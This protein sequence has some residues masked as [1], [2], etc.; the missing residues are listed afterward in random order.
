[1]SSSPRLIVLLAAVIFLGACLPRAFA[2]ELTLSPHFHMPG[3]TFYAALTYQ[4]KSTHPSLFIE[5]SQVKA[6]NIVQPS[7]SP[8]PTYKPTVSQDTTTQNLSDGLITIEE[9]I[10]TA[11][12]TPT[13]TPTPTPTS[14]PTPMPTPQPIVT[15][16]DLESLFGKYAGEYSV[17]KEQLKKIANCES[18]FNAGASFLDY[19]GMFQFS[20]SSWSSTRQQMNQDP[21]PDLRYNAEESI[22]TAAFKIS[23]HGPSAWPSC[24]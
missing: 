7:S 21:N 19:G 5:F 10:P 6:F 18:G 11:T 23:V 15:S 12:P 13:N 4:N 22:K 16:S 3:L 8:S 17:D 20:A 2:S 1:M 24:H 14:T 9:I